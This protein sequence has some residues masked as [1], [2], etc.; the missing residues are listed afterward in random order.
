MK[1]KPLLI[2]LLICLSGLPAIRLVAQTAA[3]GQPGTT[4]QPVTTTQVP[5]AG[6][7]LIYSLQQCLDYAYENQDSMK[8]ARL[9]VKIATETVRETVG[10]GLPNITFNAGLTD[11]LILSKQLL[12]GQFF[13][14]PAGTFVPITFGVPWQ[15]SYTGQA[16]QLL[17][18]ASYLVGLRAAAVVK[19][20]SVKSLSR[21]KIQ[22]TIQ[23][24]KAY[25]NVLASQERLKLANSSITRIARNLS[26]TRGMN[27]AGFAE[28]IDVQRAEVQ[29]N[30]AVTDQK[31][32]VNGILIALYALKFQIGMPLEFSL[33]VAGEVKDVNLAELADTTSLPY[34]GRIEYA[35]YETQV[36]A[37]R[38]Q[39]KNARA[40]L[41]P[42]LSAYGNYGKNWF[43]T[44]FTNILKVG[45]PGSTIGLSLTWNVFDG[46]QT[47]HRINEGRYTW[48]KSKNNL[49]NV[50]KGIQFQVQSS[51]LAYLNNLAGVQNQQRN[52]QLAQNVYSSSKIKYTE[53]IGSNLELSQA[54]ISLEE[55]ETNYI[56]SLLNVLVSKVDLDAALGN[57]QP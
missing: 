35:L 1:V 28:L 14:K 33:N 42:K 51:R 6:P 48:E 44:S 41:F 38:L 32:A 56:N 8:N 54:E 5:P 15:A 45:Y 10:R 23:V 11:N 39:W 18:D 43:S 26:D 19:S 31:Q 2:L 9:D 47:I 20:L 36:E 22:A 34:A 7:L 25:Y 52:R 57:F 17:F 4:V 3:Q 13:G 24:T 12:P 30:N 27:K 49:H 37:T 16:T 21:T 53:G 46:G 40:A 50:Q 55:A 29:Y